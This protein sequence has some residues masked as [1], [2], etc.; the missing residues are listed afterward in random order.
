MC[1]TDRMLRA[2]KDAEKGTGIA[3]EISESEVSSSGSDTEDEDSPALAISNPADDSDE[4]LEDEGGE[5][6]NPESQDSEG[7]EKMEHKVAI[8]KY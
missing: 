4:Y 6:K 5:T 2:F 7:E 8:I 3:E 1:I